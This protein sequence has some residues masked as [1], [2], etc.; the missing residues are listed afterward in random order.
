MK[1]AEK[2]LHSITTMV[3]NHY[4][5]R[6]GA[7][8]TTVIDNE[9]IPREERKILNVSR[10]KDREVNGEDLQAVVKNIGVL[11]KCYYKNEA[12]R[13]THTCYPNM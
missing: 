6:S 4:S 7:L 8:S 13:K 9:L 1:N 3:C 10:M 5:K 12:V 11:L 2:N